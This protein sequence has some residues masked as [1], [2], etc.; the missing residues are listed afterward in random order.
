M[1]VPYSWLME[2]LDA[3]IGAEELAHRLTMG[4]LEVEEIVEWASEDGEASDA[5]LVTKPTAN[6]GDML[7]MVGVA[8]QAAALLGAEYRLPDFPGDL[9]ADPAVSETV[10]NVRYSSGDAA[11][12]VF[13][14]WK[15]IVLRSLCFGVGVTSSRTLYWKT[16][17]SVSGGFVGGE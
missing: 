3:D 15:V 9:L 1:R 7:S 13:V 8:R 16:I 10:S 12:V 5:V 2:Y 11:G 6:R 4:G 17:V 14:K